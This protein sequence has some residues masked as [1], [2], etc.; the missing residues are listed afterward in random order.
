MVW[1]IRLR[2][3]TSKSQASCHVTLKGEIG[4]DMSKGTETRSRIIAKAA[5]LFNRKGYEGCTMQDI[6]EAVGLE[7]GSLY[8]HFPNK[9]ALAVASF[10][11]AWNETS[12]ARMAKMDNIPNT[13]GKLKVHVANVVSLPSFDGGCPLLNA[14]T[15]NDNGNPALRKMARKALKEW[16][17]YLQEIFKDGQDRGEIRAGLDPQEAAT[18]MIALLEGAMAL[19]RIDGRSGF[20]K[21]A[22]RHLNSYLD[23]VA[24]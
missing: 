3:L 4:I 10:E 9:E 13:I 14:I 16:R 22:G 23:T 12:S 6:V 15:D 1:N 8:G 20:L 24:S 2:S 18:L 17:L 11:Y 21:G 19:D 7:K 5:P